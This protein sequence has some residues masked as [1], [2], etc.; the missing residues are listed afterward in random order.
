MLVVILKHIFVGANA[1]LC[2]QSAWYLKV[3]KYE[4]DL[5]NAVEQGENALESNHML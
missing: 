1:E 2:L 3:A 4:A 5:A